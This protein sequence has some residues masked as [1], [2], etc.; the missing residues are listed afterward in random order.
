MVGLGTLQAEGDRILDCPP[1]AL[2]GGLT[3]IPGPQVRPQRA[4]GIAGLLDDVLG[5]LS[6]EPSPVLDLGLG[7]LTQGEVALDVLLERHGRH[8]GRGLIAGMQGFLKCPACTGVGSSFT[9][10]ANF[11][12]VTLPAA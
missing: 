11:T 5:R 7:V 10:T 12:T 3:E 1:V 8:P 9:C 6:A 2:E 4:V